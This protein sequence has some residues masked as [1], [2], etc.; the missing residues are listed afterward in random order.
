MEIGS[1]VQSHHD[2]HHRHRSF[3]RET[4]NRSWLYREGVQ[5]HRQTST[6]FISHQ[7]QGKTANMELDFFII[8]G[9][10]IVTHRHREVKACLVHCHLFHLLQ[11]QLPTSSNLSIMMLIAIIIFIM[12]PMMMTMLASEPRCIA[13][14]LP[15]LQTF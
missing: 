2:H 11:L 3:E 8:F 9:I 7:N 1:Y 15:E 13:P 6:R 14:N 12:M 4:S 10:I 5:S